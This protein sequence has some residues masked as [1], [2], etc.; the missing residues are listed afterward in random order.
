[1][2]IHLHNSPPRGTWANPIQLDGPIPEK[3][4]EEFADRA[5]VFV[6]PKGGEITK[7]YRSYEDYCMD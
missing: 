2:T 3:F 6:V 1:M 4:P 7:W 5:Y